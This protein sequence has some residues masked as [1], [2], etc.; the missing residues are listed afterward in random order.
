MIRVVNKKYYFVLVML[1]GFQFYNQEFSSAIPNDRRSMI[2]TL[3]S[4]DLR[5][6]P[7][8]L[9]NGAG[10]DLPKVFESLPNQVYLNIIKAKVPNPGD[11]WR[12]DVK[13][14][15]VKWDQ[16]LTLFLRRTGNGR[17]FYKH[18]ISGGR[19]YQTITEIDRTFMI[20]NG[21]RKLIPVQ[22]KLEGVSVKIN[23][24]SYK[25]V[26]YYTLVDI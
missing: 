5:I 16:T 15:D 8:H 22:F 18:F 9:V 4:W 20:G 23:A 21:G 19:A 10:S 17:G 6:T 25:S 11:G 1:V 3:R 12:I 13:K 24:D 14:I 26:I 2:F 7:L